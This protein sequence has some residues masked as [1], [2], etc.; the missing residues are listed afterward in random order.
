MVIFCGYVALAT[1]GFQWAFIFRV[2][3]AVKNTDGL[4][5]D[6]LVKKCSSVFSL[7]QLKCC[8]VNLRFVYIL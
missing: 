8:G 3:F 7:Q 1:S 6:H 5:R 4:H 2:S